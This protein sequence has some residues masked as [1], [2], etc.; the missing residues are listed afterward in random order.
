MSPLKTNL[1]K[2]VLSYLPMTKYLQIIQIN[3]HLIEAMN[4]IKPY[5][6]IISTLQ[7]ECSDEQDIDPYYHYFCF[8]YKELS[9][10]TIKDIFI[11]YLQERAINNMI[12]LNSAGTLTIEILNKVKSNINVNVNTN[13]FLYDNFSLVQYS[14]IR[15]ITIDMNTVNEESIN[16][17]FNNII[18]NSITE[19]CIKL[20]EINYLNIITLF[21]KLTELSLSLKLLSIKLDSLKEYDN[22]ICNLL[23]LNELNQ[24]YHQLFEKAFVILLLYLF[25]TLKSLTF[26]FPTQLKSRKLVDFFSFLNLDSLNVLYPSFASNFELLL[27]NIKQRKRTLKTLTLCP[28]SD[29]PIDLSFFDS[30]PQLK[31]IKFLSPILIKKQAKKV[32][33]LIDKCEFKPDYKNIF[34]YQPSVSYSCK[35][36][37]SMKNAV[38]SIIHN[39]N[40]EYITISCMDKKNK[41][42][43]ECSCCLLKSSSVKKLDYIGS[44][45]LIMILN[46]FP[47]LQEIN[48]TLQSTGSVV[49][50][51]FNYLSKQSLTSFILKGKCDNVELSLELLNKLNQYTNLKVLNLKNLIWKIPKKKKGDLVFRLKEIEDFSLVDIKLYYTN[52]FIESNLP[53]HVICKGFKEMNKLK[54]LSI[55]NC[56][57]DPDDLLFLWKKLELF[58]LLKELYIKS[59]KIILINPSIYYQIANY[60]DKLKN[61]RKLSLGSEEKDNILLS[62]IVNTNS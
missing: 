45:S 43:T 60:T 20:K 40:I 9:K 21:T 31:E 54:K 58:P 8:K 27:L 2:I 11:S 24:S 55:L 52:E 23:Q 19:L 48:L 5:Y 33:V 50:R 17:I 13:H 10:N 7:R 51:L 3:K 53:L 49:K 1:L 36:E 28:P 6:G 4:I 62:R 34:D 18:N 22:I 30:F 44:T 42:E 41:H 47:S 32:K 57:Y 14:N 35:S 59:D 37:I 25:R 16:Y 56:F 38:N 12:T 46:N 39:N 26:Y 29:Y 15:R 61:L